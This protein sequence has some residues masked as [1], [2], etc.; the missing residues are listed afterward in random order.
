MLARKGH[1]ALAVCVGDSIQLLSKRGRILWHNVPRLFEEP[2][3]PDE[4]QH[5]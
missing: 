5:P 3:P 1:R 2:F 4:T